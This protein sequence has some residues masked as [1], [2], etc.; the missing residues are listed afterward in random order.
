MISK[1]D[2]AILTVA[3]TN[4]RI[5]SEIVARAI[6]A[7]ADP[8]AA[9]ALLAV[10]SDSAEEKREIQEYL[11][12]ALANRSAASEISAQL[13]LIIECLQY[14]ANQATNTAGDNIIEN[15]LLNAA[16][17]KIANLSAST[18]EILV[19][20]MANR[21]S[22]GRIADA[23]DAAGVVAAGIADGAEI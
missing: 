22:A 3:I 13:D 14:Q 23:I 17:A 16:Q 12:V 21:A 1:S 6:D 11:T 2:E 5:A 10:I 4:E 20:C 19:V 15:P 18:K 8:A 7:S 9:I